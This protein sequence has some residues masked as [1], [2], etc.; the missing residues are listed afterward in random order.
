MPGRGEFGGPQ[1]CA[2]VAGGFTE[3]GFPGQAVDLAVG[4]HKGGAGVVDQLAQPFGRVGGVQR[5]EGRARVQHGQQGDHRV[6]GARQRE[7]DDVVGADPP[8]PQGA[9]QAVHPARQLS[10]AQPFPAAHQGRTRGS[11]GGH[12]VERGGHV[13]RFAGQRGRA[14]CLHHP[15]RVGVQG[16]PSDGPAVD[17]RGQQGAQPGQQALDRGPVVGPRVDLEAEQQ[18]AVPGRQDAEAHVLGRPARDVAHHAGG[19]G[20]VDGKVEG[21]E[22]DAASVQQGAGA[23]D[24]EVLREVLAP[25]PLVFAHL[26]HGG[27]HPPGQLAETVAAAHGDPQ[28]QHVD[29]HGGGA[30]LGRAGPAHQ[31]QRE[32]HVGA[33]E[34]AVQEGGV[35]GDQRLAPGD[36][37]GVGEGLQPVRLRRGEGGAGG[38]GAVG[39]PRGAGVVG[40]AEFGQRGEPLDPVRAV[41]GEPVA[42]PVRLVGGDEGGEGAEGR[43]GRLGPPYQGG[44]AGAG[45]AGE[46]RGGV[47]VE[48][49]VVA[50]LGVPDLVVGEPDDGACAER[51][52]HHPPARLAG[53]CPFGVDECLGG[54]G[55]VG[56]SADVEHLGKR[57][58][59]L[60][61]RL[62]WPLRSVEHAQPQRLG[63]LRGGPDRLGQGVGVDRTATGYLD[64]VADH[65][66]GRVRLH[67]LSVPDAQLGAG[68]REETVR[69]HACG[70]QLTLLGGWVRPSV[71][72]SPGRG[73]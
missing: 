40:G 65:V 31:G 52:V 55:R 49:Q 69:G 56:R 35:S 44:V 5:Q 73:R 20:E 7:R 11:G 14:P 19:P 33:S 64:D 46:H 13:H 27:G 67:A 30:Q 6:G 62:A 47:P 59:F 53:P 61:D 3:Q 23:G 58:R 4:D 22:V 50:E 28:R 41:L 71:C 25:V 60:A 15:V 63:L 66:V 34:H 70:A 37:L 36:A 10:G 9:G 45:A 21:L 18:P 17:E 54:G 43:P 8:G 1:R 38:Q 12:R 48:D 39:R 32:H 68:E 51:P 24:A 29:R 2:G 26:A 72:R 16:D 42:V 57:D